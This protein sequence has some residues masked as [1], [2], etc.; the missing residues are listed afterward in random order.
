MRAGPCLQ[1][2]TRGASFI[3][4]SSS[5]GCRQPLA[6]RHS[7]PISTS[8]V[9]FSLYV[10]VCSWKDTSHWIR[11]HP[12]LTQPHLNLITFCKDPISTRGHKCRFQ[13][14]M[15]FGDAIQLSAVSVS[16]GWMYWVMFPSMEWYFVAPPPPAVHGGTCSPPPQ[17]GVL[18][19]F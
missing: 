15:N 7:A 12:S 19:S 6:H 13:L 1:E 9:T 18:S 10:W 14:D 11:A 17:H 16:V 2:G 3:T 4:S 8:A 5:W